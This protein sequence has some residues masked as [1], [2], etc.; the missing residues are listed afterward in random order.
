[1]IVSCNAE[2]WSCDCSICDVV[3]V[4]IYYPTDIQL[5]PY[6]ILF[7][8]VDDHTRVKLTPI[9]DEEG[10]DYVNANY[11]PV[12]Y[13]YVHRLHISAPFSVLTWIQLKFDLELSDE[14]GVEC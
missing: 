13:T 12:S 8:S 4:Y 6:M 10:S 1:M 5:F 11:M 2:H 7:F 14:F 9:D 3:Y